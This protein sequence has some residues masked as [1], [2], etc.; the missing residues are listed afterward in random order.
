MRRYELAHDYH[1]GLGGNPDW[2]VYDSQG[3]DPET[4]IAV[5]FKRGDAIAF[6]RVKES[7]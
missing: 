4:P 7:K 5:F 2:A 6:C 1:A 3:K